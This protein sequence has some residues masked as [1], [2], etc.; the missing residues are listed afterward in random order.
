ME[1]SAASEVEKCFP[2]QKHVTTLCPPRSWHRLS[3]AAHWR[4][5]TVAILRKQIGDYAPLAAAEGRQC[6]QSSI[7]TF[8]TFGH[9][10][11][12]TG[13]IAQAKYH[14]QEGFSK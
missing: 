11:I 6:M 8:L 14:F 1:T 10:P 12:T 5:V 2:P 9:I 7:L 4:P 3:K 13:S